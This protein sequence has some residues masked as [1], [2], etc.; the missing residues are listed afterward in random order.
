M[1]TLILTLHVL[2]CLFLIVLVLLQSG[3]EGMGVIFGGSN[4][5]LF[6]SVGAGGILVKATA[7]L[8]VVFIVTSLGY[9]LATRVESKVE[10]VILAPDVTIEDLTPQAPATPPVQPAPAPESGTVP[11]Q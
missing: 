6:G 1:Q 4:T 3:K 5:S 7:V 10:S 9:T 8:A 11:A 2:A